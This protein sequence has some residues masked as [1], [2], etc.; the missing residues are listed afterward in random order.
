MPETLVWDEQLC[1]WQ[2]FVP[3]KGTFYSD[4]RGFN[5]AWTGERWSRAFYEQLE[6]DWIDRG[7]PD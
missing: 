3:C 7:C 2:K 1:C 5:V 6:R 4:N